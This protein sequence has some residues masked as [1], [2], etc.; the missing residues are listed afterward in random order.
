M[1]EN[2]Q[3]YPHASAKADATRLRQSTAIGK[4]S[5]PSDQFSGLL[6]LFT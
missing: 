6:K 2:G 5:L 3:T 1:T 4:P